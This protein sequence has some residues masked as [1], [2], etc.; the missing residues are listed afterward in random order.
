MGLTFPNLVTTRIG[1]TGDGLNES[2]GLFNYY[3]LMAGHRFGI[4]GTDFELEPS[5]LVRSVRNVPF[6][7]DF[8][9]KANFLQEKITTGLSYRSGTGGAIGVLLGTKINN[10]RLYYSYDVT[11][12]RFQRY[13]QGSHELTVS[14]DFGNFTDRAEKFRK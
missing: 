9:I 5:M 12:Q 14:F 10:L 1:D 2:S 8:N 13:N 4:E 6:Q 11:F 7:I 3:T